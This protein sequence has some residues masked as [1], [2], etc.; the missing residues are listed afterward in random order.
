MTVPSISIRVPS[1][2]KS[3]IRDVGPS[4]NTLVVVSPNLRTFCCR[5]GPFWR[6]RRVAHL[7]ADERL[8]IDG[9]L[10]RLWRGA[11]LNKL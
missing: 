6:P 4:I 11:Y 8:S 9:R 2:P 1:G 10:L 5:T 3:S 7:P